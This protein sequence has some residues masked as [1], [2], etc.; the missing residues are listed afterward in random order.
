MPNSRFLMY[1]MG[2][3]LA[4]L[5]YIPFFHLFSFD[6][7][8]LPQ[9]KRNPMQLNDVSFFFFSFSF[10]L[11]ILCL[12]DLLVEFLC[13]LDVFGCSISIFVVVVVVRGHG[14][15]LGPMPR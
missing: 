9:K 3:V 10:V 2:I 8:N 7:T 15:C 11:L 13:L 14:T 6:S 12:L 5:P 1:G 4:C